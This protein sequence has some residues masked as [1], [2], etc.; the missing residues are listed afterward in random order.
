MYKLTFKSS[1]T[2][3]TVICTRNHRW[4]LDDGTVV[5]NINVGDSLALTPKVKNNEPINNNLWCIGFVLGDGCD[6]KL[7]SKDRTHIT[8]GAM[9]IRLCG[10]KV[11]YEFA[12][13]RPGDIDDCYAC[14]DKAEK[15][16]GFKATRTLKDMCESSYKFEINNK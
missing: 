5:D 1:L 12:P 13:R 11:K 3:K 15:E 4:V 9:K 14:P 7:W 16:L 8:N 6:I 2:R 10:D